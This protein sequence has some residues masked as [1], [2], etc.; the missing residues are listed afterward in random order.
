[1]VA[2]FSVLLSHIKFT[3]LLW[4]LFGILLSAIFFLSLNKEF[5]FDEIELIHTS[6][7]IL[8]GE[9][10]YVDF[11]QHHHPLFY[12]LM[13]PVI[14]V[15][16]ENTTALVG[17]RVVV[18][19]LLVLIF[20]V[21]YQLSI[22]V[23]NKETG[24]ISLV[25][26]STTLIFINRAIELR[27][28]VPQTLF[29]LIA[30]L[31]LF[32]Y[33]ESKELK[34]LVF[35]SLSSGIA[36]LFLQKALFLG[37][38]IVGL[39]LFN[40]YRKNIHYRD[41][42]IYLF[43]I[44]STFLF[45]LFYFIYSDS[46]DSYFLF[47]WLLNIKFLDRSYPFDTFID[48]YKTNTLVWF[49]YVI[50]LLFFLKTSIQKQFGFVSFGLL[51]FVFLTRK[52][53]QQYFIP[54]IPL[55]VIVSSY[56]AG[57]MFRNSQKMIITALVLSILLPS[58]DLYRWVSDFRNNGQLQKINY[59]LSITSP[60]DYVYDGHVSF[61]VFRKD[62]DF[63]WYSLDP[64]DGLS[65]YQSMFDYNYNIYESISKYKPKVISNYFIKNMN[66]DRI[67]KYYRQSSEYN[68]LF[69]RVDTD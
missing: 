58:Y 67:A 52:T 51:V 2:K 50:G 25:L 49:F 43:V 56:T 63:F 14:L 42:L 24:V 45:Y 48:T 4:L 30:L 32:T 15:M 22:K 7:K 27:P 28:D 62:V 23:F 68:D 34:Y 37:F 31:C 46:V 13:A 53:Y 66:D 64:G 60:E 36:F 41:L 35:S 19:F 21:T 55:V 1:M 6:W 59:V 69:I 40:V 12:Y 10:I 16:G 5:S 3:T 33:L 38:L 18:F 54:L 61:N 9:R 17:A 39:L 65:T 20:V 57:F 26:L 8:Q 29:N 11:F 44:F 47:N